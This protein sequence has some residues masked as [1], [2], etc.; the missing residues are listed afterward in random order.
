MAT[1]LSTNKRLAARKSNQ[2]KKHAA[3]E[4]TAAKGAQEETSGKSQPMASPII[5]KKALS[6]LQR[7][8]RE[9]SATLNL[10]H[11]LDMA[12]EEAMELSKATR[13]AII[14]REATGNGNLQVR[15]YTGYSEAETA[16]LHTMLQ[17]PVSHPALAKVL[18]ATQALIISDGKAKSN[19]S[20]LG[21]EAPSTL[22]APVVY[23]KSLAGL[24]FLES[25]KEKV[26]DQSTLEFIKALSAQIS[27]AI[28]NA[29]R[30]DKQLERGKLLRRR[31]NQLTS[32]LKVSQALRS[33]RPL[34]T[35]LEEVAYAIQ[36]SVGF[37]LVLISILEGDP[38]H[39]RRM[40]A[41]GIPIA[42][43]ERMKTVQQP[44]ALVK[45][46]MKDKFRISQSYYI[47]AE[48]Q[49]DWHNH[50]D[51]YAQKSEEK[52]E[53]GHWQSHDMLLVPLIGPKGDTQG[54]LSVDQPRDGQ[55]P[56]QA[57]IETLEIFAGQAALAIEN[58]QLVKVLQYRAKTLALFNKVN[59][60]TTAKLD[61]KEV[62]NSVVEM[63]P[64]LLEC[65]HSNIFLLDTE[66]QRYVLQAAQGST[67][68][69][70]HPPSFAVG[71]GLMG[72]VAQSGMPLAID[73]IKQSSYSTLGLNETE[74]GP[75]ALVP[76][77][78]SNQVIG[79]L[80]MG[81]QRDQ[82]FSPADLATLSALTDQV[83]IAVEN[84][85]LFDK[86]HRFSQEL[87]ERVEERTQK[88]A[89][90]MDNL[91]K[92]RDRVE[93]LYRITSQLSTSL[94]LE[95]LL[96]QALELVV[97]AVE[98]EQASILMLNQES[99]Q[100]IHRAAW[101]TESDLP[102]GGKATRF[103]RHEGLAGWVIKH[104]KA[105]IVSD[106]QQDRRWIESQDKNQKQEYHSALVAPLL[107][108]GTVLGAL[109]LFHTQTD[110]FNEDHL[111]LLEAA[112]VQVA[113]AAKNAELY[114]FIRN[115]T[116]ELGR[117]LKTQRVEATK[118]QSILE[119]VADGVMVA[120][121]DN[122]AILI[123]A[124]AESILDLPREEVLGRTT[125]EM[126]GLYGSQAQDWMETVIKWSK[127]PQTY[128]VGE[129]LSAQLEI[130]DRIVSVH[131]APVLMENEFLG[132]VSVFRDVTAEV[133]ME[134]SKTEFVSMVSHELRT[135][136][137]SIK[138][139]VDLL[140]MGSAGNLTEK[141]QHFLSIIKNNTD[142]L[143]TL[144]NE[145]LDISRIKSGRVRL[146]LEAIDVEAIITQV[147]TSMS[148]RAKDEGLTLRQEVSPN[149]PKVSA[150]TDRVIQILTNLVANSCQYTLP[151]GQVVVSAH[152]QDDKVHISVRDTG[153]GIAPEDLDKVF[154][155]FFRADN[156]LVHKVSGTGLGLSI[157]KSLIEMHDEQIWVESELEK[158]ST[159]TFT[160]SPLQNSSQ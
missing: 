133:E 18:H 65:A 32:V 97:E 5:Y 149:L 47:P 71:E 23:S 75:V 83:A 20:N 66:T 94:D 59:R 123:N 129:Y 126:L 68:L 91:T 90:T 138:G 40:A 103:S 153:I 154:D 1:V 60:S 136:M 77:T 41:A 21:L 43:F 82:T 67:P 45:K 115:Q 81:R 13:G 36:E 156:S 28:G 148:G 155:R 29:R 19:Q 3:Q 7:V 139:Y 49:G 15:A 119:G 130:R 100:L 111:R 79:I 146:T 74:I 135:P 8:S 16:R 116:G 108:S 140:M 88:L 117:A 12:L 80:R 112:A 105:A 38:S 132:T 95:H 84:A 147:V 150:D 114:N 10:E 2:P 78:V 121:A 142:R 128:T 131:L 51:I 69:S 35:I 54:L 63:V 39:Q 157:V 127:Q 106:I 6:S 9:I 107:T 87:E 125:N 56:N 96:N 52:R 53:S 144:V 85:R 160:L 89:K 55:I 50:L 122:K 4:A 58:A 110:Y 120:D 109:L 72:E 118:S 92:E 145:L 137:T 34:E 124:A 134:R 98:A 104:R 141:Q 151:G 27:T 22:I 159:F 37:N 143:S 113:N 73:D 11:I 57:T 33:D 14:L 76:L 48:E 61:L 102:I 44:W 17:P 152:M 93:T 25:K 42:T 30:Y 70:P 64:R 158:G 31:A 101:G 62:L 26:F 46:V 86:V 24:I 99:K